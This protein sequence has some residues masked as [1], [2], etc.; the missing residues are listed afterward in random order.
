MHDRLRPSSL[1]GDPERVK[2]A[3]VGDVE[4]RS[5]AESLGDPWAGT[6]PQM[7]DDGDLGPLIEEGIDHLGSDEAGTTGDEDAHVAN[8]LGPGVVA[9]LAAPARRGVVLVHAREHE[10]DQHRADRRP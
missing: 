3:H 7:V 10:E 1:E 5:A 2:V 4:G 8:R 9:T 6:A